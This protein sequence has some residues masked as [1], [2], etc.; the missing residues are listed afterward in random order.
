MPTDAAS[1][2]HQGPLIYIITGEPSGDQLGAHLMDGL[3]EE[4]AGR[5]RFAG[6]GG[7]MMEAR[8]LHSQVPL[9]ETAVMGFLEVLPS[10]RRI[11][12]RVK[13]VAARIEADKPA[14]VVTVD[15]WGF[16]GRIHKALMATGSTIPRVHYVAPMVW[17]YKPGRAKTVAE[18]VHH[19]L[20]LWP[21][22]P[23]L[24]E[25]EGLAA[26][27][28][29]HSVVE[30]GAGHGDGAAFRSR[31]GLAEST[32][33]LCVLPG[34]RRFEV[35]KLL[36][37]FG[38]AVR[39]LAR[40]HPDMAVVIPTLGHLE[41]TVRKKTADWPVRVIVVR[42]AAEKY[43]AFAASRAAI[44]ASGTVSLELSLSGLPHLIAYRVNVLTALIFRML[45]KLTYA[46]PVNIL[47]NR[48]A[49]PELLQYD[50]TP[51]TVASVA[52]DLLDRKDVRTEQQAAMAEAAHALGADDLAPGRRAARVLLEM[53]SK[54][55]T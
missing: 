27:H 19:L 36:P 22:E 24:F 26:T 18:R 54:T 21:F 40:D 52:A 47:L 49:I 2:D 46:D 16:T 14:L 41:E 5:V 55:P 34:S 53:L 28:V 8:G 4:T 48:P 6:V 12:R 17:V 33:V 45:T 25:K 39:I 20:C 7:E 9:S 43:D 30:T 35:G 13:E 32:R 51:G 11:L 23:P 42:G 29:G 10:A 1:E 38:D 3:R 44:A 15:S 37:V 50:C 31:H